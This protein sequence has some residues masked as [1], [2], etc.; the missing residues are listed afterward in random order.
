MNRKLLT[1]LRLLVPAAALCVLLRQPMTD[2]VFGGTPRQLP[3][4][5]YERV[6][7][8]DG[9]GF[10]ELDDVTAIRKLAA[11]GETVTGS[12]LRV[13]DIDGDGKITADDAGILLKYLAETT[14]PEVSPDQYYKMKMNGEENAQ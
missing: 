1:A 3:V 6:G 11:S 2:R 8:A 12:R 9:N 10:I 14:R 5:V 13:S 7:D 4:P